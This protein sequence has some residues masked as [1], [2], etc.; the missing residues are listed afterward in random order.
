MLKLSVVR[1]LIAAAAVLAPG[2]SNM[3]DTELATQLLSVSPRGGAT[4]VAST[5]DIVLTF[6]QPMMMGME[7]YMAL[8]QGGLS[9]PTLPMSCNW[10]DSRTTLTCRP[11]QPLAAGTRYT[12]HMGGGMMDADGRRVGMER[13]GRKMGGRCATGRMMGG[14]SGMMG[15]GWTHTDGS[16]GM[17]FEFT[18]Q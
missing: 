7:Q 10:S 9:G 16:Y 11:D 13:Y 8:H 1:G 17:A 14:Q 15:A 6:N 5:T 2:C 12:V 3:M 4:G 18:T